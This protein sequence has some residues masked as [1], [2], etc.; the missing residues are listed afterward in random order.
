[1]GDVVVELEE[2]VADGV[3]EITLLGQNVNSYGRDLHGR[4][5]MFAELLRAAD[6]VDGLERIR[7]TSPHPKDMRP[8]TIA[9]MAECRSV[10]EQLHLPL[11]SGSSRV[12]AAMRRG[13]NAERFLARLDQA[14]DA[15][16]NLTVTT[17]I[18]VGFPGETDGDF[19]ETLEVVEEARFDSA[20][21]FVYSP[22]P[23]TSAAVLDDPTPVDVKR[24]RYRRLTDLQDSIS[25]SKN[26]ELVGST[27]ELL[28]EGPSKKDQTRLNG[29]TRGG[30]LVHVA[31]NG[32]VGA[33]EFREARISSATP[34]YLFADFES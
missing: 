26:L 20:Y 33:G 2:L 32:L 4:R 21:T 7:F 22:R 16:P 8:D 24:D 31:D 6:R 25:W 30:K 14:R 19:D 27:C 12:L 34:H 3:V 28:I 9:A 18:I 11:Q 5:P 1:M 17:D 13:Y 23:D 15:I 29:R 10:C